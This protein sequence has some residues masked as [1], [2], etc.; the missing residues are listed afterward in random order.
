MYDIEI[1]G[2]DYFAGKQ[3]KLSVYKDIKLRNNQIVDVVLY[4][5]YIFNLKKE[6]K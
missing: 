1:L 2:A 5:N 6:E 4:K 3:C